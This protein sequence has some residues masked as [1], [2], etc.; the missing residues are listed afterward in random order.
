MISLL[1]STSDFRHIVVEASIYYLCQCLSQCPI[2]TITDVSSGLLSVS[3]LSEI[4]SESKKVIPECFYFLASIFGLYHSEVLNIGKSL[5]MQ[6]TFNL[7][8]LSILRKSL[9]YHS[10]QSTDLFSPDEARKLEWS[11]FENTTTNEED[12]GL[13]QQSFHILSITQSLTKLMAERYREASYFSE[14]F[15]SLIIP[16]LKQMRPH[17]YPKCPS[18][19]IVN[20]TELLNSLISISNETKSKRQHLKWRNVMK[21]AIESKMPKFSIDYKFKKDN[22]IDESRTKLKQLTREKK[23]EEKAVMRELR[24]DNSFLEQAKFAEKMRK[25]ESIQSERYKNFAWLEE[26]QATINQQVRKGGE[27]LR[28][29]GSGIAKKI[30]IKRR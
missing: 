15:H 3:I 21:M 7:N 27:L 22:N 25:K 12:K 5:H 11:Y 2:N 6:K 14:L 20:H 16:N 28:G 19:I 29:A 10:N 9:S 1:F 13:F 26:Q 4:S 24:R 18:F 23:R 17:V 8:K 30:R